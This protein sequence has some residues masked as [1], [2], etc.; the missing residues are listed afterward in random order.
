MPLN[1]IIWIIIQHSWSSSTFTL[2]A[3]LTVINLIYKILSN[4][5]PFDSL[6]II[7][8]TIKLFAKKNIS[9]DNIVTMKIKM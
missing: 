7:I 3:F 8:N 6:S 2:D 4:Y 1:G 5:Q 9:L